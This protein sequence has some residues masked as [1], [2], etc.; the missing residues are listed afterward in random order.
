ML[1]DVSCFLSVLSVDCERSAY[2]V[3]GTVWGDKLI[4][5]SSSGGLH[6]ASTK[7]S[8]PLKGS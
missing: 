8:I 3:H 1:Y 7:V 2:K 5:I 6:Y 4:I